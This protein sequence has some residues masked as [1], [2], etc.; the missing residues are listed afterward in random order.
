MPELK[1]L[2]QGGDKPGWSLYEV[3]EK[4]E[5]VAIHFNDLLIRLRLQALGGVAALSTLI[6]IFAKSDVGLVLGSWEI[7]GAAFVVLAA[8]WIAIWV[9][10]IAY[11]NRLL[12]GAVSAIFDLEELSRTGR[13]RVDNIMLSTRISASVA[14]TM[15]T[16]LT[17]RQRFYLLRGV[18]IFYSIVFITLVAGAL[19]CFWKHAHFVPA[20]PRSL[21]IPL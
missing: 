21:L 20:A 2:K 12:L 6:G 5:T 4:Y 14:G 13:K 19:F 17:L 18:H 1:V 16:Q 11:Y 15:V 8:F 10:D 7:A 3:W 9:L